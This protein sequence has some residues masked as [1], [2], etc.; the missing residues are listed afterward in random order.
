MDNLFLIA[1]KQLRQSDFSGNVLNILDSNFPA[2]LA[3]YVQTSGALGN[4]I[5]YTTG[6]QTIFGNKSFGTNI[7]VPYS[8]STGSAPSQQFVLDQS[9]ALQSGITSINSFIISGAHLTGIERFVGKKYFESLILNSGGVTGE[10]TV[11]NPINSGDAVPLI[12]LQNQVSSLINSTF[13]NNSGNQN[14]SGILSFFN[15]G[16]IYIPVTTQGSGAVPL[17]Q[18]DSTGNNILNNLFN[19]GAF[20]QNQI[21]TLDLSAASNVTGFGGVLTINAQSGN[22]FTQGRGSVT[23]A[24]NGNVINIS[25]NTLFQSTGVFA[26][27]GAIGSGV[28]TQFV[29]FG[30]IYQTPPLVFAQ[31][32]DNIGDPLLSYYVS[33]ISTSGF[34]LVFSNYTSS[35]GYSI[36]YLCSTGLGNI[37][38]NTQGPQGSPSIYP[39]I[40]LFFDTYFPTGVT[41]FG[42]WEW[43][44]PQNTAITGINLSCRTSGSGNIFSGNLYSY[45]TGN[46]QNNLSGFYMGSGTY[47][48]TANCSNNTLFINSP[49]RI[50]IDILSLS[51]GMGKISF[52]IFGYGF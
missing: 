48:S 29:D 18:L 51:S 39:T 23:V 26:G 15:G 38:T 50:G 45:N 11:P 1:S 9:A 5:V 19:T 35:S 31:L 33:G 4:Y 40:P 42:L 36:N 10:L 21:S 2:I 7:N 41:G 22:L 43:Q 17:T 44:I 16:A 32:V 37:W 47:F 46:I 52:G 20:L 34:N 49:G 28:Y 8:G 27:S 14:V 24:Q 30:S 25:G 13:L 6:D 12:Y 3:G